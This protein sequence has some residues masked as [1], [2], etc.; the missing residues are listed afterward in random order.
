VFCEG[1]KTVTGFQP[2]VLQGV[3]LK[4]PASRVLTSLETLASRFDEN[5]LASA[6]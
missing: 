3:Q 6:S 2:F 5:L 1:W 4:V